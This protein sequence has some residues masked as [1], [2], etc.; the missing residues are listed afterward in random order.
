MDPLSNPGAVASMS[1]SESEGGPVVVKLFG[2]LD[3]VGAQGLQDDL[4]AILASDPGGI[5]F[6]V[7]DLDFMDSSGI[8]LLL[9]AAS[10]T[11]SVD[12]RNPSPIIRRI[13]E[14]TGLSDILRVVAE[15]SA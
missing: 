2:D 12:V 15:S 11:G 5:V 10:K 14:V 8:A 9:R 3:I 4:D 6:D 13:I 1:V 7:G